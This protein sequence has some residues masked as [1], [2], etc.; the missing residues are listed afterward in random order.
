MYKGKKNVTSRR[1]CK[2]VNKYPRI[3]VILLWNIWTHDNSLIISFFMFWNI[4]LYLNIKKYTK[5]S[6]CMQK[7]AEMCE[8][9]STL[10]TLWIY[11]ICVFHSWIHK[12]FTQSFA[13]KRGREKHASARGVNSRYDSNNRRR[14]LVAPLFSLR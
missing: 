9:R 10:R 7:Y 5:I 3:R 13:E 6:R 4:N 2:R 12:K 11:F 14:E 8:T 1:I